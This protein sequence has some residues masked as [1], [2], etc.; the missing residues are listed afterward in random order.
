MKKAG[1]PRSIFQLLAPLLFTCI[2]LT[3]PAL[4]QSE[5]ESSQHVVRITEPK[6]GKSWDVHPRATTRLKT[7]AGKR[8]HGRIEAIGDSSITV[9]HQ[10]IAVRDIASMRVTDS[11][12]SRG[13]LITLLTGL[14]SMELF[15]IFIMLAFSNSLPLIPP[16]LQYIFAALILLSPF[17]YIIGLI[18]IAGSAVHYDRARGGRLEMR[19]STSDWKQR[20]KVSRVERL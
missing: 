16:F 20:N 1:L 18:V 12:K 9:R 6:T 2:C 8:Y 10:E 14:L 5:A 7:Q 4:A 3:T 15:L 11:R 17:L 13:G 19:K